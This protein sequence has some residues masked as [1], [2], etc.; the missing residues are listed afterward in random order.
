MGEGLKGTPT[1][2]PRR[3]EPRGHFS[4]APAAPGPCSHWAL[5]S[6][7]RVCSAFTPEALPSSACSGRAS[8][9][10]HGLSSQ[11]FGAAAGTVL[12][13]LDG[14]SDCRPEAPRAPV[15]SCLAG[16]PPPSPEGRTDPRRP[17]SLQAGATGL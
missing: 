14:F 17:P 2:C 4:T 13:R 10:P 1:A 11:V 6:R 3:A 16:P 8:T 9:F 7:S 12:R 15:S 5:P